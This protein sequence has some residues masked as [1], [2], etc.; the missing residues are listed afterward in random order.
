VGGGNE[1][2]DEDAEE[3]GLIPSWLDNDEE[4]I[5][6]KGVEVLV[7]VEETGVTP[8]LLAPEWEHL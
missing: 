8:P 1:E 5:C 2:E 6:I 4:S 3:E 7:L